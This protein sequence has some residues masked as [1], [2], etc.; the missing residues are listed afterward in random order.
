M[1][2]HVNWGVE[3]RYSLQLKE[4]IPNT[5]FAGD[6]ALILLLSPPLYYFL[7]CQAGVNMLIS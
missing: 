6:S 1:P 5:E 3:T 7:Y 4:G 2:T